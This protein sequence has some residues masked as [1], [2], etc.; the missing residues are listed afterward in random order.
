MARGSWGAAAV[1]HSLHRTSTDK[2][3]QLLQQQG[4][5][6]AGLKQQL[7]QLAAG[8]MQH[9]AQQ[10]RPAVQRHEC[11]MQAAQALA[12]ANVCCKEALA[13]AQV[14]QCRLQTALELLPLE[15]YSWEHHTVLLAL[16]TEGGLHGLQ[17]LCF[18]QRFAS[19][20][21]QLAKRRYVQATYQLCTADGW[22]ST[23]L[24]CCMFPQPRGRVPR[25]AAPR[26]ADMTLLLAASHQHYLH[27]L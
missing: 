21:A 27:C 5:A 26:P 20:L 14:Q 11:A 10:G 15:G 6:V 9:A 3:V 24:C 25:S 13:A 23:G 22:C 1:C 16:T 18:M 17:L 12:I 8:Y 2:D 7:V 4:A 19:A